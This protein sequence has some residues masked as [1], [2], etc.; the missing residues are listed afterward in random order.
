MVTYDDAYNVNSDNFEPL[1]GSYST[2]SELHACKHIR[3]LPMTRIY[4][5]VSYIL[6]IGLSGIL[7]FLI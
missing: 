6:H 7:F 1:R 2:Y 5:V 4:V 3:L